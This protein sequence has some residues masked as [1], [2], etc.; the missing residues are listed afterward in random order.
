M[1]GQTVGEYRITELISDKGGF[2]IVYKAV[3]TLLEQ[4]VAIKVLKPKFTAD[5]EFKERFVTEARTQARLKHPNIVTLLN[6]LVH[7]EQYYLVVEFMEGVELP[8]GGRATTLSD[9][10]GSGPLA[11]DRVTSIFR[12]VLDGVGFAHRQGVIHRDIK[13]LNVLFTAQGLPKVAD[14]GI[15]KILSGETSVS[16][17]GARVGTPAYMSPEQVFDKK[18]TRST[19]IYSLGCTLYEMATGSLPFKESDTSSMMEAHVSEPPTPP[20]QVN[21]AVSEQLEQ[22]ILKAMQKKPQDRFQNCEE[23]AEALG[24]SKAEQ[25][26]RVVV[27]SVLGKGRAEAEELLRQAGCFCRFAENESSSDVPAGKAVRQSPAPGDFCEADSLVQVVL[28]SGRRRSTLP[29]DTCPASRTDRE[30]D[31]GPAVEARRSAAPTVGSRAPTSE[32]SDRRQRPNRTRSSSLRAAKIVLGVLLG[33][34]VLV[35]SMLICTAPRLP[36][37]SRSSSSPQPSSDSKETAL[38]APAPF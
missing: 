17:S 6:F 36:Q 30:S 27:P 9:L 15:A 10:L 5:P 20:R 31:G 11:Q 23:F 7:D 32:Y 13:P 22:A 14:F 25:L 3:H 35:T 8:S 19:D 33:F 24:E 38:G 28:S 4:E 16:L 1:I 18:L 29:P 2:G 21:P 26:R 37:Y 12:Q 34:F